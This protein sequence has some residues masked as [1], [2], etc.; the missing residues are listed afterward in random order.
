MLFLAQ[1]EGTLSGAVLSSTLCVRKLALGSSLLA[2][3]RSLGVGVIGG[4][5]MR[6]CHIRTLVSHAIWLD[7]HSRVVMMVQGLLVRLIRRVGVGRSSMVGLLWLR[8]GMVVL[9]SNELV[10]QTW[11]R[12]PSVFD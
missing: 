5:G 12:L 11:T 3:S 10:A 8:R 7:S 2:G 4:V 9:S 1:T 6:D